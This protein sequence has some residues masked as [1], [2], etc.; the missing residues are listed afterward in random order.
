M[1]RIQVVIRTARR[2]VVEAASRGHEAARRVLERADGGARDG[3]DGE[4]DVDAEDQ[5]AADGEVL[6]H[7]P[8]TGV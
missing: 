8:E 3:E 4:V 1:T 2:F 6:V 5:H 7:N